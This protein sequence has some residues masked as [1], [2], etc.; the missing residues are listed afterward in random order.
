MKKIERID[1][2]EV[3]I[4]N[5]PLVDTFETSLEVETHKEALII[6][7]NSGNTSGWG[8]CVSSPT[9]FY[10]YETNETAFYVI[11]N[12]LL[13]TLKA[14][15]DF[16]VEAVIN[17]FDRIRGHNMDKATVENALLDLYA[18]IN[19]FPLYKIIQGEKRDIMSGIS[20]GITR[21]Q[22]DLIQ[23]IEAAVKKKYHRIKIKVKK[24]E[25]IEPLK[26]IRDTF[27]KIKLM[28]DAN[29]DYLMDDLRILKK[30][31]DYNLMMIE[32][33]LDHNDLLY[34]SQLQKELKTPICLDESIKTLIDVRL[35]VHLES[36]RI[37]N[38]K[39]GRVGGILKAKSIQE[40]CLKNNI[41]VWSGGM[42]ETGIGRA[43]NIHLQ[44]LPGF[45]LPGDTSETARYFAED[46][47]KPVIVLDSEGFIKIPE[48]NGIGVQIIPE[49]L[50]K[51]TISHD[52][53][54]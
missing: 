19:S 37:I 3:F 18:K 29:A 14:K 41:E 51:Y 33:P 21:N 48:G 17:E 1:G 40:Y 54:I 39:Q 50:K 10:S 22:G 20:I 16:S 34:H 49:R 9:P 52:Q 44:S 26:M 28:V 45:T 32:Q 31:D 53:L 42:L 12:Y 47:V 24:G 43:F 5:L 2:V 8:E 46:L 23:S 11:K 7:I 36:C 25:E 38:I 6:K 4:V 13:P 15:R 35:A 27:P 30:L